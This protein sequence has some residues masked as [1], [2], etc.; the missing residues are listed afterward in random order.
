MG[1]AYPGSTAGLP[2]SPTCS[3]SGNCAGLRAAHPLVVPTIAAG[4][5]SN[6]ASGKFSENGRYMELKLQTSAN[7]RP[8]YR[9]NSVD[10]KKCVTGWLR[11]GGVFHRQ[12]VGRIIFVTAAAGV[13]GLLDA[14]VTVLLPL[15]A[16]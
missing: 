11:H 1:K 7:F 10:R 13:V 4:R 12:I 16:Q 15:G 3:M 14:E 9:C 2:P 5:V 8:L 6:F